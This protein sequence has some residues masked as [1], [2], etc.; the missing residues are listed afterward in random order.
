MKSIK[1]EGICTKKI[2]DAYARRKN[3]YCSDTM[4][5]WGKPKTDPTHREKKKKRH[6]IWWDLLVDSI[7]MSPLPIHYQP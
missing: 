5:E 6:H 1:N 4:V 2:V 3:D 7:H